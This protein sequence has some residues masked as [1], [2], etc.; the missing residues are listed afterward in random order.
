[1]SSKDLLK[2]RLAVK[3]KQ[4]LSAIGLVVILLLN[5]IYYSWNEEEIIVLYFLLRFLMDDSI[6]ERSFVRILDP[7]V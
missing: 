4:L 7:D 3:E 2:E 6:E 5:K 1:M